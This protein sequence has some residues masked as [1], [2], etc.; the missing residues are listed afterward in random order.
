MTRNLIGGFLVV[1]L[2]E[3]RLS[4]RILRLIQNYLLKGRQREKIGSSL[5]GWLEII[6]GVSQASILG[7]I[8]F[9]TFI[10]DL[11]RFI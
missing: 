8:L 4:E 1:K 7:L 11:L 9:N 3:C 2:L 10:N 5:R 6:L